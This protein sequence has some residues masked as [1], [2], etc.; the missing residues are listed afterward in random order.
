M[1]YLSK[2]HLL[3]CFD[4]WLFE[5]MYKKMKTMFKYIRQSIFLIGGEGGVTY[6]IINGY[7]L[8]NFEI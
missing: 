1:A 6:W 2:R 5:N 3:Y 8:I 7:Y 4:K